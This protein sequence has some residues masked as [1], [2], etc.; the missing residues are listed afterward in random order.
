MVAPRLDP[1]AGV[2]VA[3]HAATVDVIEITLGQGVQQL[4][5]GFKFVHALSHVDPALQQQRAVGVVVRLGRVAVLGQLTPKGVEP[6]TVRLEFRHVGKHLQR[7]RRAA[8]HSVRAIVHAAL[9][10]GIVVT[11][12]HALP[13]DLAELGLLNFT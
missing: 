7:H 5:V 6:A 2:R 11:Q 9:E 10:V 4:A 8:V 12:R 13:E 1:A 3:A